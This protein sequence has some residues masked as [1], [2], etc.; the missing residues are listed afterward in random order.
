M[1]AAVEGMPFPS[2]NVSTFPSCTKGQTGHR[3]LVQNHG[4]MDWDREQEE[5]RL[6]GT[7]L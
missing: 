5:V 6:S 3:Y 2:Q 7:R 1:M 4:R